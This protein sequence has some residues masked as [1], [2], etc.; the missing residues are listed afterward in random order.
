MKVYIIGHRPEKVLVTIDTIDLTDLSDFQ[1]SIIS[2]HM[3]FYIQKYIN[4]GVIS[5]ITDLSE[6]K[7]YD[8]A[9]INIIGE[10]TLV[11]K[12]QI[13]N[14]PLYNYKNGVGLAVYL[15]KIAALENLDLTDSNYTGLRYK[16]YTNGTI[17]EKICYKEGKPLLSYHYRND[18]YNT[19]EQ[20]KIFKNSKVE[21]IIYYDN[22]ERPLKQEW[23]KPNGTVLTTRSS[24]N[25]S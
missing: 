21:S 17:M 18:T 5:H 9:N 2:V 7:E 22:R 1:S 20:S 24:N 15:Y 14:I 8:S 13:F 3:P 11:T 6:N 25:A 4:C 16:H 23:L 12:G 10:D 19:L